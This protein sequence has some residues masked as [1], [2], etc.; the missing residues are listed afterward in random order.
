MVFR[1]VSEPIS[2]LAGAAFSRKY[3]LLGRIMTHWAEIVGKDFAARATPEALRYQRSGKGD[4]KQV[5]VF[6]DIA[7]TSAD[8][9]QLIYQQDLLIERM[10][11]I[12]GETLVNGVRF[13]HKPAN[14][15]RKPLAPKKKPLTDDEKNT[16]SSM[17][18][19][20]EDPDIRMGLES[21]GREIF[22]DM[23]N[24]DQNR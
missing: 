10:N 2:K 7:A 18:N 17:L 19:G 23:K 15:I 20:I 22:M 14:Q 8:A 4:T 9:A 6:L 3:V 24:K 21:L 1:P 5:K 11:Q 13:I 16:L 12:F